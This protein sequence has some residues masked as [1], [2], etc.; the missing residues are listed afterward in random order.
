MDAT[1]LTKN[2]A[3]NEPVNLLRNEIIPIAEEFLIGE[4]QPVWLDIS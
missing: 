1:V 4:Y 2:G 3:K